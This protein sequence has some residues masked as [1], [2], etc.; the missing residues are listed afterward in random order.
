MAVAQAARLHLFAVIVATF[1]ALMGRSWLQVVLLADGVQKDFAADLSYLVVP[2]I[3][4]A[5]LFPIMRQYKSC[6]AG[7]FDARGLTPRLVLNAIAIGVFLR[8]SAWCQLIVGISFGFYANPDPNATAGPTFSFSCAEPQV[9]VIGIVVMVIMVP[10]IEELINRGVIQ[11][12]LAHHGPVFAIFSSAL[13]FMLAHKPS[14]WGFA[15]YAGLILGI[16]F[17]RTKRLWYSLITHATVNGLIQIDWRCLRGQWN[18]PSSQVPVWGVG[19]TSILVLAL[20]VLGVLYLLHGKSAGA[21]N[22][23]RH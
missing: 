4:V 6:L 16:Q 23:P 17:W 18:P 15:F 9:I 2:L 3:L 5:L 21:L 7:L 11:S 10:I 19:L 22:A 14:S 13:L 20:A 12:W 8:L 1:A